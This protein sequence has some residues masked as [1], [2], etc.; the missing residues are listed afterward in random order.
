MSRY[1][2]G[3]L[4]FCGSEEQGGSFGLSMR[5]NLVSVR[6]GWRWILSDI[7]LGF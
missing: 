5:E 2:G 4:A 6:I 7:E 1:G 3:P